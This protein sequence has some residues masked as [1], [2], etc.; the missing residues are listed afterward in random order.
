MIKV[1]KI[2]MYLF[3]SYH[4]KFKLSRVSPHE[5]PSYPSNLAKQDRKDKHQIPLPSPL[6]QRTHLVPLDYQIT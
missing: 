6:P 4:L 1:S 3:Y 2:P 5:S